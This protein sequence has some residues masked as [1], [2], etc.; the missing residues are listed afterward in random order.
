M[1]WYSLFVLKVPL[2]NKQTNIASYYQ[3]LLYMAADGISHLVHRLVSGCIRHFVTSTVFLTL[4]SLGWHCHFSGSS[5]PVGDTV[6]LRLSA[7]CLRLPAYINT[8]FPV[9]LSPLSEVLLTVIWVNNNNN[10]NNTNICKVHIVSIRAESETPAVA[11]WR[12]WLV[13]VV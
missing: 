6:T 11:R 7:H 10:N 2:N 4:T 9:T 3:H 5:T 8:T 13:V 12:G 1:A